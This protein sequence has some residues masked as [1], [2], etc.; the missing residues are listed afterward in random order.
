MV[1]SQRGGI[2][3][4]ASSFNSK[5]RA[6]SLSNLPWGGGKPVLST[7]LHGSWMEVSCQWLSSSLR[8]A[9]RA[10]GFCSACNGGTVIS[11]GG[12]AEEE[13]NSL[14]QRIR[15]LIS[16]CVCVWG[17]FSPARSHKGKES[18][19]FF[20]SEYSSGP[21]EGVGTEQLLRPVYPAPI[22]YN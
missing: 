9:T 1:E 20:P 14:C 12:L 16:M 13:W 4:W 8:G 11:G 2:E 10:L 22:R 17:G 15:R 5:H 19:F 7:C 3:I 6:G 18:Y 21:S